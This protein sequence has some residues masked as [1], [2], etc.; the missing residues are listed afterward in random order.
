MQRAQWQPIDLCLGILLIGWSGYWLFRKRTREF[1]IKRLAEEKAKEIN[2]AYQV[3]S[4]TQ[5]R[6]LYRIAGTAVLLLIGGRCSTVVPSS[7]SG[8]DRIVT[9][10]ITSGLAFGCFAWAAWLWS[11]SISKVLSKIGIT[12]FA[13]QATVA[14]CLI[15]CAIHALN[16]VS[17]AA[18]SSTPET[19]LKT[20]VSGT[21]APPAL[22]QNNASDGSKGTA[23]N[24]ISGASAGCHPP[25]FSQQEFS[26]LEQ[27]AANG[28]AAAQ[29]GL[30][31]IL[32]SSRMPL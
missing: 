27:K 2:G 19:Q 17:L 18:R 4:D 14:G 8:L 16:F 1:E 32:A 25:V 30:G 24:G 22:N 29:C 23:T 13:M 11:R 10:I 3:L 31:L 12:I 7:E 15:V 28:D 21:S 26:T 9:S 20:S 5:K 6:R